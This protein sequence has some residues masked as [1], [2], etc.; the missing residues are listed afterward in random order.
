M[1][2]V[3]FL[4]AL[5][6]VLLALAAFAGN[7]PGDPRALPRALGVEPLAKSSEKGDGCAFTRYTFLDPLFGVVVE[8]R[9]ARID[10]GWTDLGDPGTA[11]RTRRN[12]DLTAR[13][14]TILTGSDGAEVARLTGGETLRDQPLP[15]GLRLSGGCAEHR[16]RLSL[17]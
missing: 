12:R 15:G 16:C 9:C 14:V 1:R 17:R 8:F 13:V 10:I 2:L 6:A 7:P 11:E 4:I 3:H 5:P